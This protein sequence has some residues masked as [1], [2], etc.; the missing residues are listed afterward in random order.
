MSGPGRAL[1]GVAPA[2]MS[3]LKLARLDR[4]FTIHA[5]LEARLSGA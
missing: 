1:V 5:S 2:A 4:V 3:V